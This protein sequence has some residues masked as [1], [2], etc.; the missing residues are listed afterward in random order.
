MHYLIYFENILIEDLQVVLKVAEFRSIT[1]AATHLD[2]RTATAS[3]A[4][5][6]AENALGGGAVHPHNPQASALQYR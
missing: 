5:K 2:M 1:A 4:L 3:A 6:R